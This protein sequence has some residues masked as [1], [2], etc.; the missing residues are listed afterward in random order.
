[1]ENKVVL[2][3]G[4]SQGVGKAHAWDLAMRGA[5][6]VLNG[7]NVEKLE[8]AHQ[9]FI[10]AGHQVTAISGDIADPASCDLII[11]H[12]VEVFGRVD[13][14][15]NNAALSST[16][17]AAE[18]VSPTVYNKMFRVNSLGA[19]NMTITALPYLKKSKGGVL[20]ISTLAA[21]HGIP[22]ASAYSSSK[23]ALTA[24]A[25]SLRLEVGQL[26]VYVGVAYLG[27]VENDARKTIFNKKGEVISQKDHNFTKAT[28][29]VEIARQ[30]TQM[31]LKRQR[32]RYFSLM[33][34]ALVALQRISPWLLER[35]MLTI[36]RRRKAKE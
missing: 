28:S 12:T 2:I 36:Y 10:E 5:K 20:F 32:Y 17:S 15:I 27:F 6:V 8:E 4:S 19:I 7:R 35:T 16:L 22:E 9:E 24:F 11:R 30:L 18:E 1:M 26:G 31:L 3:T 23:M 34:K 14:L 25:Q 21:L 13:Y 29:P 33:G